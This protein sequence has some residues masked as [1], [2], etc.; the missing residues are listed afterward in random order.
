MSLTKAQ[1]LSRVAIGLVSIAALAG[2]SLGKDVRTKRGDLNKNVQSP[3]SYAV[4]FM[5]QETVPMGE[6]KNWWTEQERQCGAYKTNLPWCYL[7][8]G[9]KFEHPK[10]YT[11]GLGGS[12]ARVQTEISFRKESKNSKRVPD[13]LRQSE[14]AALITQ[15]ASLEEVAAIALRVAEYSICQGGQVRLSHSNGSRISGAENMKMILSANDASQAISQID[16]DDVEEIKAIEQGKNGAWI[17]RLECSLWGDGKN[18]RVAAAGTRERPT[19][20]RRPTTDLR[21]HVD[22]LLNAQ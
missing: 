17:V 6:K 21:D 15:T 18:E 10:K 4:A 8:F 19:A 12:W 5:R 11:E 2:C 20:E 1:K 22:A 3:P 16:P 14:A 9:F 7:R 13:E